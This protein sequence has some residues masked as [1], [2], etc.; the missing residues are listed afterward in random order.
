M[1]SARI[2]ALAAGT[3]GAITIL[4]LV[5]PLRAVAVTGDSGR[6]EATPGTVRPGAVVTVNTTACGGQGHGTGDASAVGGPASF[7]LRPGAQQQAVTGRFIVPDSALP[8]TYGLGVTCGNGKEAVGDVIVVSGSASASAAVEA[9]APLMPGMA[10]PHPPK[11][12]P[13]TGTSSRDEAPRTPHIVAGAALMALA[14]A[15]TLWLV[16][17]HGTNRP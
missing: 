16:R 11:A 7:E 17:R 6:L 13:S 5:L 10:R 15:G 12:G 1:R 2:P 9:Q 14:A 8:G 3:A 4:A